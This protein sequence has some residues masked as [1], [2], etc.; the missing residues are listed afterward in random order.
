[1]SFWFFTPPNE[2]ASEFV[3]PSMCSFYYPSS[4]FFLC[5]FFKFLCF[6]STWSNM[7]CKTKFI[8][9]LLNFFSNICCIKT[10]I[11]FFVLG[12]FWFF[13]LYTLNSRSSKFN[14]MSVSSINSNAK[15]YSFC[16]RKNTSFCTKLGSVDGTW[17]CFFFR[18]TE[19]W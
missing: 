4:C 2:Y 17:S 14:I 13:Y 9:K 18:L 16:F 12:N 8:C 19:I 10:K 5:V 7:K 1:M 6:F 15:G 11:L 3:Q